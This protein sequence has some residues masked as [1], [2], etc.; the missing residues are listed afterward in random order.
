MFP[1]DLTK[2]DQT[3]ECENKV[4]RG[5]CLASR[6]EDQCGPEHNPVQIY[7][8]ILV[9]LWQVMAFVG[10]VVGSCI[11]ISVCIT[12]AWL[13]GGVGNSRVGVG[14]GPSPLVGC[15]QHLEATHHSSC[16]EGRAFTMAGCGAWVGG[17][18]E[19]GVG[20][21]MVAT[22]VVRQYSGVSSLCSILS[23]QSMN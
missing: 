21:P 10:L 12:H 16:C 13:A 3:S 6:K 5:C 9:G 2:Q 19:V 22:Q 18:F 11:V 17:A 1:L 23:R 15:P 14:S 4:Q 7:L 8:V 20:W